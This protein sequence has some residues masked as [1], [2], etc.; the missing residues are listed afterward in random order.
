MTTTSHLYRGLPVLV[1]GGVGF[2]GSNLALRLEAMGARVTIV[3]R[4]LTQYG[5][6]RFNLENPLNPDQ[7]ER[8]ITLI[9][10]DIG[11]A[12][13]IEQAVAG[14]GMIFNIA[15][16]TSHMDSMQKPLEDMELNQI[17][18][19]KFLDLVRR[20]N[21]GVRLVFSS[22]RQFY[23]PPRY[24]PVDEAHPIFPPD[25]NGVHKY[26]AESYHM[27]YSRVYGMKISALRLTNV[28]GPRMRIKDA[29]QTFLGIWVRH[30]IQDTEFEVWGG[31]QRRDFSYVDDL[32]DALLASAT[33]EAAIG[34]VYNV[35][36]FPSVTLLELA[37]LLVKTAKS[38]RYLLKAF[39]EER[40]KIDIGDYYCDDTAFRQ[41][42]GWEPKI[43]MAEGLARSLAYYRANSAHYL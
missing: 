41:A 15:G 9:E 26:A 28:Y 22:T 14:A 11:D 43:D 7:G 29:K 37:D 42:T 36:G 33:S 34:N 35:G 12:E 17:A 4:L 23:G 25:I 19:I 8:G 27:L 20:V 16:Q 31:D 2:I 18:N 1:T 13:K 5:A 40:K 3:D 21:P 6:N 10:A 39:P 24:L 38:G 30:A 32:V